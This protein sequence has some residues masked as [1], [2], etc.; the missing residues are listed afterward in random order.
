MLNSFNKQPKKLS[1]SYS[2]NNSSS[3]IQCPD[4]TIKRKRHKSSYKDIYLEKLNFIPTQMPIGKRKDLGYSTLYQN[5]SVNISRDDFKFN[6]EDSGMS[7]RRNNKSTINLNLQN[8]SS[9]NGKN[10]NRVKSISYVGSKNKKKVNIKKSQSI[11]TGKTNKKGASFVA[12]KPKNSKKIG[13]EMILAGLEKD[14]TFEQK[15]NNKESI[16]NDKPISNVKSVGILKTK[17]NTKGMLKL[18]LEEGNQERVLDPDDKDNSLLGDKSPTNNKLGKLDQMNI[19]NREHLIQGTLL[20]NNEKGDFEDFKEMRNRLDTAIQDNQDGDLT[21][22]RKGNNINTINISER[23]LKTNDD[24]DKAKGDQEI[25]SSQDILYGSNDLN[26]SPINSKLTDNINF[27]KTSNP[28][29]LLVSKDEKEEGQMTGR[30]NNNELITKN[31]RDEKE[32]DNKKNEEKGFEKQDN[33]E[34]MNQ[35]NKEGIENSNVHDENNKNV[36]DLETEKYDLTDEKHLEKN[37]RKNKIFQRN[38]NNETLYSQ[39]FSKGNLVTFGNNK[40]RQINKEHIIDNIQEGNVNSQ[41]I[42]N[43]MNEGKDKKDIFN[44]EENTKSISNIFGNINE[45]PN[46]KDSNQ[47]KTDNS[48][49][50]Q[51]INEQIKYDDNNSP[52]ND[53]EKQTTIKDT[54]NVIN[55][56]DEKLINLYQKNMQIHDS[57]FSTKNYEG[58]INLLRENEKNILNEKQFSNSL[59]NVISN[60]EKENNS[61]NEIKNINEKEMEKNNFTKN[62]N[63]SNDEPSTKQKEEITKVATDFENNNCSSTL[64]K[65]I[66]INISSREIEN[67]GKEENNEIDNKKVDNNNLQ[68]S[69]NELVSS[70]FKESESLN[71]NKLNMDSFNMNKTGNENLNQNKVSIQL[72]NEKN[73]KG[74]EEINQNNLLINFDNNDGDAP[75]SQNKELITFDEIISGTTNVNEINQNLMG[76][77]TI[78]SQ[79]YQDLNSIHSSLINTNNQKDNL[80]KNENQTLLD[81]NNEHLNTNEDANPEKEELFNISEDEGENNLP[82][83]TDQSNEI[84][85]TESNENTALISSQQSPGKSS[86]RNNQEFCNRYMT[87]EENEQQSEYNIHVLSSNTIPPN[88]TEL[89]ESVVSSTNLVK[90]DNNENENNKNNEEQ[91]PEF[92]ENEVNQAEEAEDEEEEEDNYDNEHVR[93]YDEKNYLRHNDE[94]KEV[95]EENEE[96][97][98]TSQAIISN[99]NSNSK[100][101]LNHKKINVLLDNYKYKSEKSEG[102]ENGQGKG[103]KMEDFDYVE[104]RN[105]YREFKDNKQKSENYKKNKTTNQDCENNED[106]EEK[107]EE[108]SNKNKNSP[109]K[110]VENKITKNEM[111]EN[112]SKKENYTNLKDQIT[113]KNE[114]LDSKLEEKVLKGQ[115]TENTQQLNE[116][117]KGNPTNIQNSLTKNKTIYDKN[118]KEINSNQ[119]DNEEKQSEFTGSKTDNERLLEIQQLLRQNSIPQT[120]NGKSGNNLTSYITNTDPTLVNHGAFTQTE[121]DINN[122]KKSETNTYPS[123]TVDSQTQY[124]LAGKNFSQHQQINSTPDLKIDH[125]GDYVTPAKQKEIP[126]LLI[127]NINLTIKEKSKPK[128][129]SKIA[130]AKETSFNMLPIQKKTDQ[131]KGKNLSEEDYKIFNAN[132]LNI[133]TESITNRKTKIDL[134]KNEE[135][136]QSSSLKAEIDDFITHLKQKNKTKEDLLS[137]LKQQKEMELKQLKEKSELLQ[138]QKLEAQKRK[139]NTLANANLNGANT[140]TDKQSEIESRIKR[141]LNQNTNNP[142]VPNIINKET[143]DTY[144][145]NTINTN[146]IIKKKSYQSIFNTIDVNSN[147][148]GNINRYKTNFDKNDNGNDINALN[149]IG[150]EKEIDFFDMERYENL[151]NNFSSNKD[152]NKYGNFL[153]NENKEKN[154]YLNKVKEDV[155][156]IEIKKKFKDEYQNINKFKYNFDDNMNNYNRQ[157]QKP[158][159][160]ANFVMPANSLEDVLE[161]KDYFFFGN[162]NINNS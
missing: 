125:Q 42:N 160:G 140:T 61:P 142:N 6:T 107:M 86:K 134:K 54:K 16:E 126:P 104:G 117:G 43:I 131:N 153:K 155:K 10:I 139:S 146:D 95:D 147:N 74:N 3:F 98:R 119:E 17:Y 2:L 127:S 36:N 14:D 75:I 158:K 23:Q 113:N 87:T 25:K 144:T 105:A 60:P 64:L 93:A 32:I 124:D 48:K 49:H 159:F 92:E 15:M 59:E 121:Y 116:S 123:P 26:L 122:T 58:S 47:L 149:K 111:N 84:N 45:D 38:Q 12:T 79:K 133:N 152:K 72:I 57:Q 5:N 112:L 89:K 88:S 82:Q 55:N 53:D 138:R 118:N 100:G 106:N 69:N 46:F 145:T 143:E 156:N 161:A 30:L 44:I 52:K 151:K 13:T 1:V 81:K 56:V 137:D 21:P 83:R 128:S 103:L 50:T 11:Q 39:A 40:N 115:D 85:L 29:L 114:T 22:M 28:N 102:D 120:Q 18:D 132:K 136:L 94:I 91:R 70:G 135:E 65:N 34:E 90:N 141:L 109:Y 99:P 8:D 154:T 51:L 62:K 31:N 9:F 20:D 130:L 110:L 76:S 77:S 33:I 67:H 37:E 71:Q 19:N 80:N 108:L 157:W 101:A 68:T 7:T 96:S 41:T 27:I 24:N 4:G 73:N 63:L 129:E 35:N 97:L 78:N 66:A 148:N 162:N 150:N